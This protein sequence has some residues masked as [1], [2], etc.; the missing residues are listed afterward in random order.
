MTG[1]IGLWL[2]GASLLLACGG[3]DLD[4]RGPTPGADAKSA[5]AASTSPVAPP[6]CPADVPAATRVAADPA[7][8]GLRIVGDAL[9]YQSSQRVMRVEKGGQPKAVYASPDLVSAWVDASGILVVSSPK[10]PDAVLKVLPLTPAAT[11][12]AED[13]ALTATTNWNAAGTRV[14][15]SD[16]ARFFVLAD[17]P[18]GEAIHTVDRANP[19]LTTAIV[20]AT[21]SVVTDPQISGGALWFVRDHGRVF[22]L[23]LAP[24]AANAEDGAREVFGIGEVVCGLAVGPT[25]A[26]CAT[27]GTLERRDHSGGNPTTLLD[28]AKSKAR[29]RLGRATAAGDAVIV[30]TDAAGEDGSKYVLRS[31]RATGAAVEERLVACGRD[32]ILDVAVS[33]TMIAWTERGAGVFVAP[34]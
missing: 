13:P 2:G 8:T 27:G 24:D 12:T 7:A 1:K 6:A 17:T 9:Y 15:G 31:V 3:A 4:E 16:E 33:D 18:E 19:S 22:R 23:D 29:A 30:R 11:G 34:R 5:E 20:P 21:E 14:F 28:L 32:A 10:S 25:Y 26:F